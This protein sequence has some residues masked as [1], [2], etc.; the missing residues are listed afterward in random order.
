VVRTVTLSWFLTLFLCSMPFDSA[1]RIVDL[2]FYDGAKVVFQV[3][4]CILKINE[5]QLF[6]SRDDGEAMTV[7][8]S[9]L[10]AI[11]N[12]DSKLPKF[13][14]S[15]MQSTPLPTRTKP[16]PPIDISDLISKSH[17]SYNQ[18]TAEIIEKMRF[19]QRMEVVQRLEDSTVRSIVRGLQQETGFGFDELKE[20]FLIFREECLAK[21]YWGTNSSSLEDPYN[22]S[23]NQYEQYQIDFE[24]YKGLFRELSPWWCGVQCDKLARKIFQLCDV[25][26]NNQINF[27][28]FSVNLGAICCGDPQK[29]LS[30]LYRL[31]LLPT[32]DED[33]DE[34]LEEEE[35]I[36]TPTSTSATSLLPTPSPGTP[37]ATSQDFQITDD[38]IDEKSPLDDATACKDSVFLVEQ[39][40]EDHYAVVNSLSEG[41]VK[42]SATDT[43]LNPDEED[44]NVEVKDYHYY[45][46]KYNRERKGV[47]KMKDFPQFNQH[48]FIQ[49][50]KT[51]YNLFRDDNNEQQLYHSIATVANLLLQM[52]EVGK[53]FKKP[54]KQDLDDDVTADVTERRASLNSTSTS[55]F[56][57]LSGSASPVASSSPD[58]KS[59][60]KDEED[61]D[62]VEDRSQLTLPLKSD[63]WRK[64]SSCYDDDWSISFEQFLASVLTETALC[65]FFERKHDI[66]DALTRLR[67]RPRH[68]LLQHNSS[69]D[70]G[71]SENV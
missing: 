46:K 50:C 23:H 35:K 17:E 11:T 31:H 47:E 67:H 14:N 15:S 19:K 43:S 44:C 39:A 26:E 21:T 51:L 8:A 10:M 57:L 52:G 45:L 55:S 12:R 5:E 59:E 65:E 9:Y 36:L 49:L 1:V 71:V 3:A 16:A 6:Q 56:C 20:L 70:V 64:R 18:I 58:H 33:L 69:S 25:K 62:Q 13:T 32:S 54:A 61:K 34:D 30:L 27:K 2:F 29:K 38:V 63:P 7:L 53:Q 41:V 42:M 48:Q 28:D 24:Q 40:V 22:P 37:D 60:V 68:H 66:S 4:L